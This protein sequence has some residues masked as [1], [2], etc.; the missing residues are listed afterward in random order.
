MRRKLRRKLRV[1]FLRADKAAPVFQFSYDHFAPSYVETAPSELSLLL[2][3]QNSERET[4]FLIPTGPGKVHPCKHSNPHQAVPA[5]PSGSAAFWTPSVAAFPPS[6]S[7]P[8]SNR[9][10]YSDRPG[11]KHGPH[12]RCPDEARAVSR[13]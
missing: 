9:V 6:R 13:P 10:G 1:I 8:S 7:V 3:T 4:I 5:N 2:K 12:S 11:Q